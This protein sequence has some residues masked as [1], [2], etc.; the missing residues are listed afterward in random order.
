[1]PLQVS[2]SD[3]EMEPAALQVGAVI[4]EL[5]CERT[6]QIKSQML[7]AT[8]G[9]TTLFLIIVFFLVHRA[10]RSITSPI[11]ELSEVVQRIG[12]GQLE[13]RVS[14]TH[15]VAELNSLAHGINT[16][17]A[18][19]QRENVSLHRQVEEATRIAAIAFESHEG[20]A[21][22][23]ANGV[24]LR[25][26]SAFTKITGYSDAEA[27]GQTNKI[28]KSDRQDEEFYNGMWESIFRA[29]SWQG[30]I[31]NCHKN[32]EVYPAWLTITEVKNEDGKIVNYVS[33]Y[34]DITL[35]KVAETE[36]RNLAF[37]DALTHLPNRR[38]LIDRLN[39]SMTASKRSGRFGALM[40]I[41]L[42]NF[43]PLNDK[44]GHGVGDLLLI[45]VAR[46]L[47]S[48]VRE[49]DT[50]A[51]FGGDEFVVLL[52]QLNFDKTDSVTQA[53]IVAEKIRDI[54]SDPYVLET[55]KKG[56]TITTAIHHCTS[57]I[58]VVTF[59][60]HDEDA[61][62]VLKQADQAMYRAKRE[63]RDSIRFYD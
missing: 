55:N 60:D 52:S 59:L 8:I 45:E 56:S 12:Q 53:S 43:K 33:T 7:W 34:T 28:L 29:G 51:R 16:M 31:W 49:V 4:I 10:S 25:I 48:C 44:Y 18:Q 19:L 23:D 11:R 40:F 63:G 50:V 36:I 46:R 26:N 21:I 38:M 61:E 58:G 41:D 42:D 2:L 9:V 6:D 57:S 32:G 24:I 39:L 47:G 30:E 14:E 1:M 62:A 17:S 13:A 3:L 5:S 22:T 27:V 20:M 15:C 37:Y 54:L 35:R